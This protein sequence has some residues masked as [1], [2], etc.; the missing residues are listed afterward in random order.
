LITPGI[1]GTATSTPERSEARRKQSP[2]RP[3]DDEGE[4][5]AE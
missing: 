5:Y 4:Q 2:K 1:T 3:D